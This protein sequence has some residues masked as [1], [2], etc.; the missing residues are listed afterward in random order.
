MELFGEED[1]DIA[2][3]EATEVR[4]FLHSFQANVPATDLSIPRTLKPLGPKSVR[5]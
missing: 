1:P 2:A 4:A 3:I 5:N